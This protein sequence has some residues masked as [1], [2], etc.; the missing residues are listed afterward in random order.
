MFS[1]YTELSHSVLR[2]RQSLFY[3]GSLP[4]LEHY[5]Q[6]LSGDLQTLE[7]TDAAPGS[8]QQQKRRLSVFGGALIVDACPPVVVLEWTANPVNDMFAD[9]ALAALLQAEANPIPQKS[10][11]LH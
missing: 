5:L 7:Q 10:Q 3:S 1:A 11:T 6:Q 8:G 9:A 4:L 2:Q